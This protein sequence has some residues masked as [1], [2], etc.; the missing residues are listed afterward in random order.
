MALSAKLM[1]VHTF[2][3]PN[4]FA[5]IRNSV[6]TVHIDAYLWLVYNQNRVCQ[7]QYYLDK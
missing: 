4:I 7:K 5:G 2:K 3:F 6:S 1:Q